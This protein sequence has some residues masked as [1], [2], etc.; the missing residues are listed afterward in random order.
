MVEFIQKR[1][2]RQKL[3]N[4][5]NTDY[6]KYFTKQDG[7]KQLRPIVTVEEFFTIIR[8]EQLHMWYLLCLV[9]TMNSKVGFLD[10]S[11]ILTQSEDLRPYYNIEN[12]ILALFLFNDKEHEFRN[13]FPPE[14]QTNIK[15]M[16]SLIKAF[17]I[18]VPSSRDVVINDDL[19][20]F[21][22]EKYTKIFSYLDKKRL[23]CFTSDDYDN[24]F[25]NTNILDLLNYANL[26]N[27]LVSCK[28]LTDQFTI[29]GLRNIFIT[30]SEN[31]GIAKARS[32]IKLLL[33]FAYANLTNTKQ[34]KDYTFL[35]FIIA[36]SLD[37]LLTF[38]SLD[39]FPI[40]EHK[41]SFIKSQTKTGKT[42]YDV[43]V[44]SLE[45]SKMIS[46]W[47]LFWQSAADS[48]CGNLIR[49]KPQLPFPDQPAPLIDEPMDT[50]TPI[51]KPEPVRVLNAGIKQ[52]THVKPEPIQP[53]FQPPVQQSILQNVKSEPI[54]PTVQ[55]ILQ[56]VKSEPI[57]PT[58]Q[59]SIF[60]NVKS[61][62]IQPP[63]VQQSILQNVD[64]EMNDLENY[65]YNTDQYRRV[66]EED[67]DTN[68]YDYGLPPPTPTF[69]TPSTPFIPIK[70]EPREPQTSTLNTVDTLCRRSVGFNPNV[71]VKYIPP[72]KVKKV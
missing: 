36:N 1:E 42:K 69:A 23:V 68:D 19:K 32:M 15:T 62:P 50:S 56:N 10:H 67:D 3:N 37:M 49:R 13:F 52:P 46:K 38:S 55:Q 71:E 64:P 22:G 34:K 66:V 45:K 29:A 17:W 11:V 26:S 2:F 31:Q 28:F 59:Q 25:R 54:R 24:L 8:N 40:K 21:F 14:L 7:V 12:F 63:A 53:T 9:A 39:H 20:L 43:G 27:G 5:F 41:Y 44:F 6:Q 72:R 35:C 60:Q 65:L 16:H 48:F 51:V 30:L 47:G 18:K 70:Q 57:R 33:N 58:V 4:I 61:E